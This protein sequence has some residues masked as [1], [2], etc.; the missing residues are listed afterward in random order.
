MVDG[1]DAQSFDQ[2]QKVEGPTEQRTYS[3]WYVV[4]SFEAQNQRGAEQAAML[5]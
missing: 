5:V 4:D 3:H 2:R 1:S